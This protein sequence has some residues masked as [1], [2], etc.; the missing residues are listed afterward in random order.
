MEGTDMLFGQIGF[1]CPID[2]QMTVGFD[3]VEDMVV[4]RRG[5]ADISV[6]CP[7]CGM[8]VQITTQAPIIPRPIVEAISNDLGIPFEDDKIAFSALMGSMAGA[9]HSLEFSFETDEDDCTYCDDRLLEA[10]ELTDAQEKHLGFFA[11]ELDKLDSVNDFLERV[12]GD[13]DEL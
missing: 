1:Q 7:K 6:R 12:Q 13:A 5:H 4:H 10:R 8:L 3:C 9:A 2:G 11:S